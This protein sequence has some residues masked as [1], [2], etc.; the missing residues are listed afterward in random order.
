MCSSGLMIGATDS[1][2]YTRFTRN[3]YRFGPIWLA[4]VSDAGRIH[5]FDERVSVHNYE[6]AIRFYYSVLVLSD[7]FTPLSAAGA[8][9]EPTRDSATDLRRHDML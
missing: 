8:D 7:A 9:A 4:E 2:H 1:R 3:I 5:G 6:L